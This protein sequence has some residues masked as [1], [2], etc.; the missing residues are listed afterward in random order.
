MAEIS[1]TWISWE[2]NVHHLC[3]WRTFQHKRK[4]QTEKGYPAVPGRELAC[5]VCR[6]WFPLGL[7]AQTLTCG[8]SVAVHISLAGCRA[9]KRN[10]HGKHPAVTTK[11]DLGGDVGMTLGAKLHQLIQKM[12]RLHA[13]CF[14]CFQYLYFGSYASLDTYYLSKT[15]R[16]MLGFDFYAQVC[17]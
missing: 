11:W 15:G 6:G 5:P 3:L 17:L 12:D 2:R 8:K 13:F 16:K 9:H 10:T 1:L 7:Q 4:E 14:F